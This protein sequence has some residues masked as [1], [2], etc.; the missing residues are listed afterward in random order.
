MNT[1]ELFYKF[2]KLTCQKQFIILS[3]KDILIQFKPVEKK[4]LQVHT[5]KSKT[6]IKMN[7]LFYKKK[8]PTFRAITKYFRGIS[9]NYL[10]F[11]K[12]C[13]KSIDAF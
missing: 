11:I 9:V 10:A 8:S 4:C 13:F 2:K 6:K 5:T 12:I 7:F 1:T 3:V